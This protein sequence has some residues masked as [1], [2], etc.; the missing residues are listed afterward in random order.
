MTALAD[1][2]LL[3]GGWAAGLGAVDARGEG[4]E[5]GTTVLGAAEE[6]GLG[7]CGLVL[8]NIGARG[9]GWGGGGEGEAEARCVALELVGFGIGMWVGM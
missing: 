3:L 7:W 2:L 9:G 8:V 6:L 1:G 5:G 4:R